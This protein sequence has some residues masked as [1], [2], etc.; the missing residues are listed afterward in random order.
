M[1]QNKSVEEVVE[2]FRGLKPP[3]DNNDTDGWERL[4][5][6]VRVTL[7]QERQTSHKREREIVDEYKQF[8]LNI[9]DGVDIADQQ[10]G[11]KGG[12]TLAI[13]HALNSRITNPNK[14]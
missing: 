1:S 6:W 10:M 4:D 12:G 11:N 13:R 9:L 2:E 7:Q 8:V 14:D 5:N 3:E